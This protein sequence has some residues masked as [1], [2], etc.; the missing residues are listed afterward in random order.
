MKGYDDYPVLSRR[1]LIGGKKQ[2]EPAKGYKDIVQK[3]D[4]KTIKAECEEINEDWKAC[5]AKEGIGCSL[6]GLR[7][8]A[9]TECKD[10]RFDNYGEAQLCRW[11]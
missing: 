5:D 6:P 1:G 2:C 11:S 3:P 7:K 9:E 10:K 4:V 8:D